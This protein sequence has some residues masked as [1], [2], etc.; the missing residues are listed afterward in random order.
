MKVIGIEIKNKKVFFGVYSNV[1]GEGH[2]YECK[3]LTL[4]NDSS[5]SLKAF[6]KEIFNVIGAVNPNEIVIISRQ[7]KGRFSAGA[8]SFKIE[9]LI[10]LYTDSVYFI[11]PAALRAYFKK[12]EMPFKPKYAYNE[13]AFKAAYCFLNTV[14]K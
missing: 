5:D 6:Q 13:N 4:K 7:T 10:Q 8:V 12:N 3:S 2:L 11:S 9:A 1:N 14:N